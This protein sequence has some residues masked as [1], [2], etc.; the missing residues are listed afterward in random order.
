MKT[1]RTMWCS[2]GAVVL[3][4]SQLSAAT[5]AAT[6]AVISC[7]DAR[8]APLSTKLTQLRTT[9]TPQEIEAIFGPSEP[10]LRFVSAAFESVHNLT[11]GGTVRIKAWPED[12]GRWRTT[13]TYIAPRNENKPPDTLQISGARILLEQK[14]PN[15]ASH[16]IGAA[17]PQHER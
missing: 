9:S 3:L 10:V 1:K 17:A 8:L 7:G 15:Q 14:G 6:N 12:G 5:N 11:N 2:L 13:A 4:C 16:A